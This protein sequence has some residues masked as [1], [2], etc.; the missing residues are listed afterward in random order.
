MPDIN[1]LHDGLERNCLTSESI[2]IRIEVMSQSDRVFKFVVI[3]DGSTG[4]V[5]C[6]TYSLMLNFSVFNR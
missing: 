6:Y 1:S 4:K 3:G 2:S 5:R